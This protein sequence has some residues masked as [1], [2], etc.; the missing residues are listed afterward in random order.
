[1]GKSYTRI[2]RL[3]RAELLSTVEAVTRECITVYIL[4]ESSRYADADGP[5][6]RRL[7]PRSVPPTGEHCAAAGSRRNDVLSAA[8]GV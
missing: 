2:P 1:M 8:A 4:R 3:F 5:L 6:A 7:G